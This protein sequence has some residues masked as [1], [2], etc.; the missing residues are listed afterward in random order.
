M[1]TAV[2]DR[3]IKSEYKVRR[4]EY[5]RKG[6]GKLYAV[7]A[8]FGFKL[9]Y[10]VLNRIYTYFDRSL[11][12]RHPL[13]PSTDDDRKTELLRVNTTCEMIHD[14]KPEPSFH[15]LPSLKD[16]TGQPLSDPSE[17]P[18]RHLP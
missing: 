18:P 1:A 6:I 8:V 10:S 17:A 12:I 2:V 4:R 15:A 3:Y 13:S 5:V 11:L 14:D 9:K 16:H 7:T